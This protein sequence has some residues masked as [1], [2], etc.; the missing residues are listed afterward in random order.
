MPFLKL[1]IVDSRDHQECGQQLNIAWSVHVH[2]P[3]IEYAQADIGHE[4]AK[5]VNAQKSHLLSSFSKEQKRKCRNQSIQY[6][7]DFNNHDK[8]FHCHMYFK[9]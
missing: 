3:Q 6:H 5:K 7:D 1:H 2:A 9:I 8:F 4:L